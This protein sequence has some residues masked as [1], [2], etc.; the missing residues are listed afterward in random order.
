M[1]VDV[2]GIEK[3]LVKTLRKYIGKRL[4]TIGEGANQ[5]AS[6]I[7]SR[8]Y[9]LGANP[10]TPTFPDYPYASVDYTRITDEGVELT[11]REFDKDGNYVYRTHKLA[12]FSISFYG[13]SQD[14]IMSICNE[15]HMLLEVDEVRYM[16]TLGS[17]T[18][19]R[20]RSK[21]DPVFVANS[22]QDK[23]REVATFDLILAVLDEVVVP[24]DPLNPPTDIYN[25]IVDDTT[26]DSIENIE[27]STE[28]PQDGIQGGLYG[29]DKDTPE[30]HINVETNITNP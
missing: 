28:I 25:S 2:R 30:L 14:D 13:T 17:P 29:A 8:L 7:R 22:L 11:D 10:S 18:E 19:A 20:V 12:S 15:M 24:A 1:A 5:K 4:S 3:V 21:S 6:V 27:M 23:Y 16:I 26:A 9:S